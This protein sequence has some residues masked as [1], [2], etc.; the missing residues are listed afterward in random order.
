MTVLSRDP[1]EKTASSDLMEEAVDWIVKLRGGN[2]S[3]SDTN[4]FADWLLQDA[5]HAN[6]F[7]KAEDFFNEMVVYAKIP[8][9]EIDQPSLEHPPKVVPIFKAKRKVNTWL[10]IPLA[11]ASVWLLAVGLVMPQQSSLLDN[12]FSDYHTQT[13]E[14]RDIQL[15]DGSHLLLNTNTA[16]S[17]DYQASKRLITLNHGQVRLTVAKDVQRPFEVKADSLTL[18][19]LG[20]VFDVY[21]KDARSIKVTVQEH[22]VAASLQNSTEPATVDQSKAVVIQTGQQLLYKGEGSLPEPTA[23]NLTQAA[24][25]QQHL[26]VINN[27]PLSELIAEIDRYRLGRIYLTDNKL[28]DLKVTGVFPL[29]D[30]EDVLSSVKKVLALQETKLGPWWV[31]LHQ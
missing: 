25:W 30:P 13:G 14:I 26:L 20:T 9:V 4:A 27:R 17:V 1:L 21:R 3:E 7:A 31:L 6:A 12:F 2:L 19:A 5:E 24:A 18:R 10:A 15:S 16:V 8:S 22:A 11:M 29:D 28:K 23:V